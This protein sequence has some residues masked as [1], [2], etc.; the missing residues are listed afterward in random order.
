MEA[1]GVQ[2]TTRIAES[3]QTERWETWVATD[4]RFKIPLLEIRRSYT[5]DNRLVNVS[6]KMVTALRT[7]DQLDPNLFVVPPKYTVFDIRVN[8]R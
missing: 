8:P 6:L 2:G 3:D 7:V 1:R 4:N 5:A